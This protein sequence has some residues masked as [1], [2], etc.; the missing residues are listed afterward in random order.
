VKLVIVSPQNKYEF[1]V[2]WIEAYTPSGNVVIQEGHAP[3]IVTLVAGS[4]F[5][6]FLPATDEKKIIKLMRHGFLEVDRINALALLSQEMV[7]V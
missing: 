1:D 5:S 4:D 6:F 7:E 3:I 2:A